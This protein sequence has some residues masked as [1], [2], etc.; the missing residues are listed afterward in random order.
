[1]QHVQELA[2]VFMNAL[3]V[4]VEQGIDVYLDAALSSDKF[5][6]TLFV[7]LL[8]RGKLLAKSAPRKANLK[9]FGN[10]QLPPER[11]KPVLF[12]AS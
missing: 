5:G 1:M 7:D 4:Y 11:K 8:Y 9:R 2:F 12:C 6:E 10:F 3:D